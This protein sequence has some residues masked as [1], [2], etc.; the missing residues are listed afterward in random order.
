MPTT[1]RL[2]PNLDDSQILKSPK[3]TSVSLNTSI[4]NLDESISFN[5]SNSC[6]SDTCPLCLTLVLDEDLGVGCEGMCCRWFHASCLDINEAEYLFMQRMSNIKFYCSTCSTYVVEAKAK[7]T[8]TPTKPAVESTST[9]VQCSLLVPPPSDT[10]SSS[11]TSSD[12]PG[13]EQ[14][15]GQVPVP[16]V[17]TQS[18][19]I[20]YGAA[21]PLSNMYSF[22]FSVHGTQ[23]SSLEQAY[24]HMRAVNRGNSRLAQQL[25]VCTDPFRCKRLAGTLTKYPDKDVEL[26]RCLLQMKF[27]Q[28]DAFRNSL[29]DS[30]GKTILHSTHAGDVFW[31]TGLEHDDV[32]S[33]FSKYPGK[34]IFGVLLSELREKM[35]QCQTAGITNDNVSLLNVNVTEPKSFNVSSASQSRCRN[36][37]EKGHNESTCGFKKQIFCHKCGKIGHKQ[38]FCHFFGG[39]NFNFNNPPHFRPMMPQIGYMPRPPGNWLNNAPFYNSS[40]YHQWPP[41]SGSGSFNRRHGPF[42][43]FPPPFPGMNSSAVKNSPTQNRKGTSSPQ[44]RGFRK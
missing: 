26:M 42:A 24:H 28:C 36:C 4:L 39:G 14:T 16:S 20:V 31:C 2:Y 6:A 10:P 34:N 37:F 33:H 41:N 27:D 38:K 21:D 11:S 9:S 25:L 19:R 13:D 23:F 5:V 8:K 7:S 30:I 1:S 17:T 3:G 18:P 12:K 29:V 32:A 44:N 15:G 22:P 35:I 43:P 40:F